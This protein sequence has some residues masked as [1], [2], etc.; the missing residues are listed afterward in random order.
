MPIL[1]IL[2]GVASVLLLMQFDATVYMVG[3]GFLLALVVSQV[4]IARMA[5]KQSKQKLDTFT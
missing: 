2:G 5:K 3:G 1:P 4:A